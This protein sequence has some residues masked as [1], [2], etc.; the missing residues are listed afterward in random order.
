[1]LRSRLKKNCNSLAN[2]FHGEKILVNLFQAKYGELAILD[3]GRS[4][5][6]QTII[7]HLKEI[8]DECARFFSEKF[9]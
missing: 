3:L 1:M 5:H 7:K 6:F 9:S 2:I 4:E 8:S